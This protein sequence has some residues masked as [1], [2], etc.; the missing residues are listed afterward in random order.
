M[1]TPVI[2]LPA[3]GSS[4]VRRLTGRASGSSADRQA[5][6]LVVA[7]E[8]AAQRGQVR[9][10]DRTARRLG[11]RAQVSERHLEHVR[12]AG[13]AA[14]A[15][16]RRRRGR[17]RAEHPPRRG[18][19][20]DRLRHG[21]ARRRHQALGGARR[22][23][24]HP[25][26]GRQRRPGQLPEAVAQQIGTG[27]VAGNGHRRH[28]TRRGFPLGVVDLLEQGDPAEP[29]GDRVAELAQQRRSI[30]FQSLHVH[31][32]PQGT[33]G[34]QRRGQD[35]LGQVE[36][37]AQR[38]RGGQRD[39]AQVVVQVEVGVDDP[40]RRR[41]RDRR[42]HHLLP[43]PDDHPAG[44]LH[45]LP[46]PAPVGRAVEELH[47]EERGPGGRVRLAPVHQVVQRTEL[48]WL[49]GWQWR[50]GHSAIIVLGPGRW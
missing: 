38:A 16:Q 25:R 17:R 2:R 32:F 7:A 39:P 46:Q 18:R 4:A 50:I 1:V 21:G 10:V 31:R 37:L 45:R 35:D 29:V 11:R 13:Q 12:A 43:H 14:P 34:V 23:G 6:R 47:A 26:P 33:G 30:A 5:Q 24:Q 28:G 22:A 49:S 41:G 9:V 8:T 36:Q 19:E 20:V 44:P 42:H 40:A 27:H 15:Q 48:V 3:S